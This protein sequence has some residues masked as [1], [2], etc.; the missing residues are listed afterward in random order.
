VPVELG[1]DPAW[2]SISPAI[3]QGGFRVPYDFTNIDQLMMQ[4]Y[5]DLDQL[6]LMGEYA[7]QYSLDQGVSWDFFD[8]VAGPSVS[9]SYAYSGNGPGI[10]RGNWTPISEAAKT[11]SIVRIISWH[12]DGSQLFPGSI[13]LWGR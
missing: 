1:G 8:G 5:T 7:A 10:L 2:A 12:S 3:W 6:E 11:E 4:V 13:S 9:S